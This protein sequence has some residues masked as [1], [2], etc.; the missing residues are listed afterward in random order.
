M[1]KKSKIPDNGTICSSMSY[2]IG[3]QIEKTSTD[4]E[5]LHIRTTCMNRSL[6]QIHI[7]MLVKSLDS[8][9][10][11]TTFYVQ[12]LDTLPLL[13]TRAFLTIPFLSVKIFRVLYES[14][15]VRVMLCV[16][17]DSGRLNSILTAFGSSLCC[18]R[19]SLWYI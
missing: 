16:L 11:A 6:F 10:S 17:C 4:Y 1:E 19:R 5:S 2:I 8:K 7:N 9:Q 18:V 13:F 15:Y 12:A 3:S 14:G